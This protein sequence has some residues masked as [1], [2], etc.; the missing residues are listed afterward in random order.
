MAFS[1]LVQAIGLKQLVGGL[2]K[3]SKRA[4]D[5]RPIMKWAARETQKQTTR[6]FNS[7]GASAGGRKWPELAQ[8][9][10]AIKAARYPGKPMLE[11]T[12][13]LKRSLR[14]GG[15]G[16]VRVIGKKGLRFGTRVSY[17]QDLQQGDAR[18]PPRPFLFIGPRLAKRVQDA[19]RDYVVEGKVPR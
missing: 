8:A 14:R 13:K 7:E 11:R 6:V 15:S 5:L 18:T 12:G 19:V 16:H 9:T 17:A 10:L 2:E 4:R 1:V 3:S